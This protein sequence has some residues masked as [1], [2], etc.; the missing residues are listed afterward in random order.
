MVQW[1][2]ALRVF[3][4]GLTGVFVTLALLMVSMVI[5]GLILRKKPN[6]DTQR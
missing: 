4:F 2:L 1:D 5:L 3:A 6:K